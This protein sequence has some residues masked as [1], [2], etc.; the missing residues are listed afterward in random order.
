MGFVNNIMITSHPLDNSS[1]T[2][3]VQQRKLSSAHLLEY[4]LLY[5]FKI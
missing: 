1:F 3:S 5:L 4:K 2:S